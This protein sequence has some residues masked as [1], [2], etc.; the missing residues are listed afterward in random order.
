MI[1]V[2]TSTSY[3]PRAKASITR[4]SAPSA[5]W[6]CA[7]TIRA[8]GSSWRS[9]SAC[10]SI[11]STRLWT[12]N[13]LPAAIELAQDR[14]AD[15]AGRRLRDARLDR[16]PVLRRRL[17]DAHVAHAGQRQVQ[18]PRD[19]RRRQRQDVDLGAHLLEPLLVGDAEAL[20][21]VDDDQ[22]Q[23]AE[24]DV[25]RQQP[26]RA[27]DQVDRPGRQAGNDL[28]LLVGGTN[29]DSM[30]TVNGYAAKRWRNVSRCC[31]A[32]TVVGTSTATCMPS[33]DRP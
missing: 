16:Q 14:V 12:K 28:L 10:A 13:D 11:V 15:Q 1:V 3:S 7:T 2:H 25:L 23:V 24:L 31:A 5:I 18:R 33:C 6:P 26:M 22:A 4:S 30:R 27:D 29:R 8:W 20:L 9:C 32:S 19:R 21:L 17:D